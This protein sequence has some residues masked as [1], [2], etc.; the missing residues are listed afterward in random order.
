MARMV[1]RYGVRVTGKENGYE[2]TTHEMQFTSCTGLLRTH[3]T[4]QLPPSRLGS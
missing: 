2:E 3:A 4:N 1:H